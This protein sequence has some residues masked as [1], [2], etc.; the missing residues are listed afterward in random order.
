MSFQKKTIS[1]SSNAANRNPQLIP[2][3]GSPQPGSNAQSLRGPAPIRGPAP[4][5]PG[6]TVT[7]GPGISREPQIQRPGATSRRPEPV[8]ALA[9]QQHVAVRTSLHSSDIPTVTTGSPDLDRLL[10]HNGQPLGSLLLIEESGN[11]DFASVLL[12]SGA[13]QSVLQSRMKHDQSKDTSPDTN[14][15][16]QNTKVVVVNADESWGSELPGE[17]RDKKQA[18][19]DKIL[20]ELKKLSV[21]NLAGK[22]SVANHSTNSSS[23]SSSSSISEDTS[24]PNMKIAWRY[25]TPNNTKHNTSSQES[26]PHY[27]TLLDFTTRLTPGPVNSKEIEYVGSPLYFMSPAYLKSSQSTSFLGNLYNQIKSSIISTLKSQGPHTV[28]RVL[29]PS[30]LHPATYSPESSSPAEAVRFVHTLAHLARTEFP[31]NVAIVMTLALE[32]FPREKFLTRWIEIISDAVIH[33]E[34]FGEKLETGGNASSGG[35]GDEKDDKKQKPYQ[36]LIHVYKVPHLSEKGG[37]HIRRSEYAFRVSRKVFEIDEWGIPI[38]D[39]DDEPNQSKPEPSNSNEIDINAK[40][41]ENDTKGNTKPPLK[42]L[43]SKSL[44]F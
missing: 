37:M 33:I 40:E 43:S 4:V 6:A 18:K 29:I 30:F 28:I 41:K 15:V 14:T 31:F 2:N 36:G 10:Q 22:S 11:T 16:Y 26:K 21:E 32:L 44:E 9:M 12:R 13:A 35:T 38:E 23:N 17:Y 34:P 3:R 19:K 5:R 42:N 8:G 20:A 25:G 1:L 27:V 24:N 7:T 39:E